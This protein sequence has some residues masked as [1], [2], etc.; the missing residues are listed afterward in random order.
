MKAHYIFFMIRTIIENTNPEDSKEIKAYQKGKISG[1][2]TMAVENRIITLNTWR[3]LY[4]R[5]V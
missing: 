5:F 3:T 4:R 1:I 2:L